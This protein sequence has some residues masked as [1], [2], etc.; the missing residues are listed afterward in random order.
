MKTDNP[1]EDL[2]Q[3]SDEEETNEGDILPHEEGRNQQRGIDRTIKTS[4]STTMHGR[5]TAPVIIALASI[6]VAVG[7]FWLPLDVEVPVPFLQ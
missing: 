1:K 7:S 6:A 2:M 4:E 3:V 5:K